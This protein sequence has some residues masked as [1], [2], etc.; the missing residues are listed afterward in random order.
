MSSSG[1]SSV[2]ISFFLPGLR[3][4]FLEQAL[5]YLAQSGFSKYSSDKTLGIDTALHLIARIAKGGRPNGKEQQLIF[6]KPSINQP[7]I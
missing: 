1:T 6:V 4:S 7:P 5:S 3:T 2:C